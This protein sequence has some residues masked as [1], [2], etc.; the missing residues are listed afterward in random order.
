MTAFEIE[1]LP[2]SA[3]GVRLMDAQRDQFSNWPVVYLIHDDRQIYVGETGNARARMGQ[4]LKSR[5]KQHLREVRMVFDERFNGSACLDLESFLIRLFGGDERYEVLNRNEGITDRD[6]FQRTMYQETFDAVF[7]ELRR[8]GYFSGTISE[9]ENSDLFKLSPYKQLNR[10]QETAV[11][12]VMDGLV[13]DLD[14]PQHT[15]AVVQGD[16]GTGKT[17]VGIY[18]IKLLRDL[19]QFDPTDDVEGDSVFSDLFL[20]GSREAFEGLSIA[21]VVPQSSLRESVRRVFQRIPALRET[22]VLTPYQ[23]AEH[24]GTF[25]VLVVDE[26]HRLTQ[27]ASQ[28][29]GT[30]TKKFGEIVRDMFGSDDPDI[31]QLDWIQKKARHTVLLLDTDQ[32][33]RPADIEPEVFTRVINRASEEQR[34]YRLETQMRVA[35]GKEYLNVVRQ[36]LSDEPPERLP[37]IGDYEFTLFDDLGAMRRRIRERDREHGLARLV[38]G[39]AWP[40]RSRKDPS[41]AD[42]EIDG[43]AL[44]WNRRPVDWIASKTSLEEVGS[45]HTV[46]GY[47]LNY[48]GVIIGGDLRIDPATGRLAVNRGN[49]FDQKGKANNG[50]RGR[51]T[52]DDDLLRY[53]VNIY[54]VLMTRGMRGTYVYV[55]DPLLRD[56]FRSLVASADGCV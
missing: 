41:A 39:Y 30:L 12:E 36:I 38:A 49:Y 3:E 14:A 44:P 52:T 15:T 4:H 50:M 22:P 5:Q 6:Y 54:R 35:G 17:I 43:V 11:L 40:W 10:E 27:R 51:P 25:D 45:I 8:R 21:L 29:H 9:I 16:P 1:E 42:I 48:A 28:S 7:T 32:S 37:D 19:A 47:D 23:V 13:H 2:F 46:Q 18:L 33:V 24:E 53:V 20:A 34:L 55:V 26:A 56:R 31:N